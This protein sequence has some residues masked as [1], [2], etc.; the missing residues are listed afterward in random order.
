M[1]NVVDLDAARARLEE[2]FKVKFEER[3]SS[4]F[5]TYYL[6]TSHGSLIDDEVRLKL[7]R[8]Q[9]ENGEPLLERFPTDAILL[10]ASAD[11]QKPLWRRLDSLPK[12]QLV[13]EH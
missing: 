9:E 1:L 6:F 12:L 5:G 7:S 13:D 3:S 2:A 8:N 4:Y 11:V 10:E